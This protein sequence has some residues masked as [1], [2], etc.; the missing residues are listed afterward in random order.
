MFRVMVRMYGLPSGFR[1]RV[2]VVGFR[3]AMSKPN[4]LLAQKVCHCL[5]QSRTLK[6]ISMR[7]AH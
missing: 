7:V 3:A 5:D 6:A 4:D 2:T 1:V